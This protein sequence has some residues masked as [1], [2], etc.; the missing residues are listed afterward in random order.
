MYTD[1]SGRRKK[2]GNKRRR[3]ASLVFVQKMLSPVNVGHASN[4]SIHTKN[5]D[6]T[7]IVVRHVG[8]F[9]QDGK[10]MG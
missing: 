3:K 2:N 5:S 4:L 8:I 9:Y 10:R 6:A 7:S 1:L